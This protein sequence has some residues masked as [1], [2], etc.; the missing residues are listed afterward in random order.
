MDKYL[1]EPGYEIENAHFCDWQSRPKFIE[2]LNEEDLIEFSLALNRIWLDL[3]KRVNTSKL[4]DGGVSS[5]LPMR[6]PFVVPG[7][8]FREF[9]YWDTYWTMEGLLV[10]GMRQT[11]RKMLENL[12]DLVLTYG[13]IPNGTRIYYLNRSQPPYFAQMVEKYYE[14]CMHAPDL[15]S[16]AKSECERFVLEEALPCLI[17]EYDFW[18]SERTAKTNNYEFDFNIFRADTN[19]PRPESYLEDIETAK[20]Y[21]NEKDRQQLFTD[22]ASAAESGYDFCSRWFGN[23]MS[24]STIETTNIIPVDLNSVMYKNELIIAELCFK[25]GLYSRGD[26]FKRAAV[27]RNRAINRVLWSKED[28]CWSDY[29]MGILIVFLVLY[30]SKLYR[31]KE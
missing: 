2:Y 9:Y 24:L 3:Y 28:L 31:K 15:D 7:G 29:N 1:H 6:H 10:C 14:S 17:K 8:R 27:K 30:S 21:N 23:L 25:K 19:K 22:I 13:F 20:M 12:I 11:A 26:D 4:A 5:H 18:M 16:E